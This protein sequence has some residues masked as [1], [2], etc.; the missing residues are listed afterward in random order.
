MSLDSRELIEEVVAQEPNPVMKYIKAQQLI[1]AA[2]EFHITNV[3]RKTGNP[4]PALQ[5]PPPSV[6]SYKAVVYVLLDGGADTFNM[7]AP[8][9]CTAT[10][11]N[12]KTLLQQY[13][14]E[15]TTIGMAENERSR[16]IDATGQPCD[17]FAIH[18]ELEIVERLYNQGD[19]SFFANAGVINRPVTKENYVELTKTQ[20]FAHNAMQEEAQKI[21]PFEGSP[22]TGVLGRMCD[23]L[24]S[25]GFNAQPITVEDATVATVGVPGS[26]VDPLF[27]TSYGTSEF[28][29]KSDSETFDPRPYISQLNGETDTHSSVFGETYSARL[30]KAV[31][32][33]EALVEALSKTQVN[34]EFAE[35]EYSLKLQAVSTL[36]A[37]HSERDTD[38]DVFYV[39]LSGWDNHDVSSTHLHSL[40]PSIANVV[41]LYVSFSNRISNRTWQQTFR[42]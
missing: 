24:K 36:I 35:T 12:G 20:L 21:D 40:C 5:A 29:P 27:V 1:V 32:D 9:S 33:N 38:R 25:K 11:V 15:R 3:V 14:E 42:S 23:V 8:H 30:Q 37:S 6:N 13:Y 41:A 19:L 10:N 2:P 18:E 26:A 7:L 39:S 31:F 22:G 4:R 17:Q 34:E 16:V 28:L